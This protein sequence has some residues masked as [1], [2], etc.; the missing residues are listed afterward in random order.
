MGVFAT[1]C[2]LC[3]CPLTSYGFDQKFSNKRNQ[4][5]YN[6]LNDVAVLTNKGAMVDGVYDDYGNIVF[7]KPG[8]N[9]HDDKTYKHRVELFGEDDNFDTTM[10]PNAVHRAC[11]EICGQPMLSDVKKRG[12]NLELESCHGQDFD[13][14]CAV[15]TEKQ[16]MLV[17]PKNCRT[18]ESIEN[19]ARIVNH[20]K[21]NMMKLPKKQ[22]ASK[23]P[24]DAKKFKPSGI[25]KSA[26]ETK[27]N[28][29]LT[30]KQLLGRLAKMKK[31]QL[32]YLLN[33]IQ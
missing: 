15:E 12:P 4:K 23:K 31:Q 18:T 10:K 30:K 9:V 7:L 6:W 1:Y 20:F 2:Y 14:D 27:S 25:A 28:S 29:G 16:W 21:N 22:L 8:G 32:V 26:I 5:Q 11:W 24:I 33:Q 13:I 3:S 19:K 17:N